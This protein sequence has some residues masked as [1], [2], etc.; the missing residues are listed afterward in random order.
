[1][2]VKKNGDKEDVNKIILKNDKVI[3]LENNQFFQESE[4]GKSLELWEEKNKYCH[5]V[6]FWHKK[7]VVMYI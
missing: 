3:E 2:L 4:S 7:S 6:C 1:M 5:K